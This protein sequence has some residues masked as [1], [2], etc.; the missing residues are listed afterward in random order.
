[1]VCGNVAARSPS[2]PRA[3]G[4]AGEC[5][6]AA[7]RQCMCVVSV[8]QP[9]FVLR[10]RS[11]HDQKAGAVRLRRK[12]NPEAGP[13]CI[14]VCACV[15][16]VLCVVS[17]RWPLHDA[18]TSAR[19]AWCGMRDAKCFGRSISGF[20]FTGHRGWMS[21]LYRYSARDRLQWAPAALAPHLDRGRDYAGVVTVSICGGR[22]RRAPVQRLPQG[23]R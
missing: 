9:F 10:A 20:R 13:T 8:T 7:A 15:E 16:C 19:L 22:D 11:R 2:A 23:R 18:D 5:I 17:I 21:L 14:Q 12:G 6:A 3:C 1:M 4:S